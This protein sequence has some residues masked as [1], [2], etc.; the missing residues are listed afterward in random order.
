SQLGIG[1]STVDGRRAEVGVEFTIGDQPATA[2]LQLRRADGF[3]DRLL[4][5]WRIVDGV[6]PLPLATAPAT[7][8]V[9]GVRVVG[10]ALGGPRTLPAVFG[11]YRVGVPADDP[12]SYAQELTVLVGSDRGPMADLPLTPDPQA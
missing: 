2:R 4:H 3:A 11:G 9:N 7:V 6:R 12:L 1:Q 5:R 10:Q 8:E